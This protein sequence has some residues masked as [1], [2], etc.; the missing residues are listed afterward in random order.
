MICEVLLDKLPFLIGRKPLLGL[1]MSFHQ[2]LS[3]IF[4]TKLLNQP[5]F[6]QVVVSFRLVLRAGF[7]RLDDQR[8]LS[9]HTFAGQ[10]HAVKLVH[11]VLAILA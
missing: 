5:S 3:K 6:V 2:I 11:L 9:P 8:A 1:L 7:V 10:P 4:A